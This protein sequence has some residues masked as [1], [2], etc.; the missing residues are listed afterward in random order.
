MSNISPYTPA[1]WNTGLY[2]NQLQR[3]INAISE[4]IGINNKWTPSNSNIVVSNNQSTITSTTNNTSYCYSSITYTNSFSLESTVANNNTNMVMGIS[5]DLSKVYPNAS[6][7]SMQMCDYAMM[8]DNQSQ[9]ANST[10]YLVLNGQYNSNKVFTSSLLPNIK[11]VYDGT[12]IYFYQNNVEI[13]SFRQTI[14]FSDKIY[15]TINSFYGGS[16]TN[17]IWSGTGGDGPGPDISLS[18]V[19]TNGNDATNQSIINL[20][21]INTPIIYGNNNSLSFSADQ[22]KVKS[23]NLAVFQNNPMLYLYNQSNTLQGRVFDN[24]FYNPQNNFIISYQQTLPTKKILPNTPTSI[25]SFN[26]AQTYS[27][28]NLNLNPFNFDYDSQ[29][30]AI[31]VGQG[32]FKFY[33][34]VQ[35]DAPINNSL[36]NSFTTPDIS[37]TGIYNS[38]DNIILYYTNS[39]ANTQT[40]YLNVIIPYNNDGGGYDINNMSF[41]ME[42]INN[43]SPII[44]TI[45][46]A[47]VP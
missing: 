2:L 1:S 42:M 3:E 25:L 35:K 16:L 33:I 23:L 12:S 20:S 19:L 8:V 24:V 6:S 27:N 30:T 10:I 5:K 14:T 37:Q 34:T 18:E 32:L 47:L 7:T 43:V 29:G 44:T 15:A 46:P 39:S 40:L 26:L 22:S 17:I 13:I 9:S 41:S 28:Y 31:P 38:T 45:V 4:F 11:M 36:Q 21:S